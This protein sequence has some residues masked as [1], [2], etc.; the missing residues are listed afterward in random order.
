MVNLLPPEAK[1]QITF[2]YYVRVATVWLF[3]MT[4]AMC[5]L[6]ALLVPISLL[7]KLQLNAYNETYTR[8][9]ADKSTFAE[10][11]AQVLTANS[12]ARELERAAAVTPLWDDIA[13]VNNLAGPAIALESLSIA[14]GTTG[15]A[16]FVITGEAATR[17]ELAAFR[18]RIKADERFADAALPLSNLAKDKEI[19]FSITI[20]VAS[21]T[22]AVSQ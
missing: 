19:P 18:D 20:S 14:R 8:V 11:E 6:G 3:L 16:S 7:V 22:N 9:T 1:R 12:V 4:G 13:L 2:E 10:A 5:V 15:I 21:S 17:A